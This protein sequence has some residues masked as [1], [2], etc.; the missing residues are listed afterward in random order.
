MGKILKLK[1]KMKV[2]LLVLALFVVCG[3]ATT[4]DSVK[5][6][7]MRDDKKV[8][9]EESKETEKDD[10]KDDEKKRREER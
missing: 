4:V 5:G 8:T 1:D 6:I 9:K 3:D 2:S 7:T 10:K